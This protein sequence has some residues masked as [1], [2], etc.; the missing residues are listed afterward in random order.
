MLWLVSVPPNSITCLDV[1]KS[2]N[3][4]FN[5]VWLAKQFSTLTE[6]DTDQK[7]KNDQQI[8][9]NS[10]QNKFKVTKAP[11]SKIHQLKTKKKNLMVLIC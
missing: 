5:K 4:N 8:G 3:Y 6:I 10:C 11:Q 2:E 9:L 1:K 7:W